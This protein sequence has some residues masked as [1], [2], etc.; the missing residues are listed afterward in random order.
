MIS[1]RNSEVK[2][3]ILAKDEQRKSRIASR[4]PVATTLMVPCVCKSFS[5][6]GPEITTKL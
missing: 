5:E 2:N 6:M 1:T 3:W 4:V